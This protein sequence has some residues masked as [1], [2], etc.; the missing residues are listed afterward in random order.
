MHKISYII[1]AF[2]ATMTAGAISAQ[3]PTEAAASTEAH[4][5]AEAAADAATPTYTDEQVAQFA[6]AVT[7]VDKIA[8][9][10][11]LSAEEKQTQMGAA[12][13]ASGLDAATF[14]EMAGSF[15]S[16]P[17]LKERVMAEINAAPV[18]EAATEAA[19]EAEAEAAVDAE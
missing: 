6:V 12:V 11:S 14:N 16:D 17:A 18:E 15:D 3:A 10:D 9:N 7:A 2:G 1:A 4:E 5:S 13:A 19:V 8:V